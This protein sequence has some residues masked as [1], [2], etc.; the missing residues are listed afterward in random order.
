M[1]FYEDAR[2]MFMS[3]GWKDFIESK[4]EDIES[5]RIENISDEKSFWM[6]KGSL[7]I[8][9]QIVGYDNYIKHLEMQDGDDA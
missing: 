6:A 7:Y 9:H 5:A 2:D 4:Q 1:K 3:Q 8:L